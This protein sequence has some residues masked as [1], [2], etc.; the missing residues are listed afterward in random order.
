VSAELQIQSTTTSDGNACLTV[1][2]EIDLASAPLFRDALEEATSTHS[3]IAVDLRG[4]NFLDSAG[5]DALFRYA[6]KHRIKLII[7][8]NDTIAAVVKVTGLD[9]LVTL[10][11]TADNDVADGP[12]TRAVATD[13][14]SPRYERPPH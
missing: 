3:A 14:R 2:G 5:V 9:Q 4:V 6:P 8:G 1:T 11:T 10:E 7:G 12:T 13:G